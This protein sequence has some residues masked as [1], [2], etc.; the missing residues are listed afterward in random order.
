MAEK[1]HFVDLG[2]ISYAGALERQK[3]VHNRLVQRKL[4]IREGLT[5][6]ESA[7]HHLFF[8]EHNP[9]YTLGKHGSEENLLLSFDELQDNNIEFFKT[10]RGGDITY[11]GPGQLVGYPVF[12]LDYFYHDVH[13]YVYDIEEVIILTLK[14]LGI[15][16]TRIKGLTGVWI[17]GQNGKQ[18]RKICAIG[19]HLSRWVSMHGFALNVNTGL[20]YFDNIIPC[21]IDDKTKGVTSI[22]QETG[23]VQDMNKIKKMVKDNFAKVF[24]FEYL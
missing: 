7:Q 9:V 16:G 19:I 13:K 17:K 1:V 3:E 11:H 4:K 15:D 8:C 20:H 23:V 10:S 5:P 24:G 14:A 2:R 21:G 22:L 12:D 6:G 18:D